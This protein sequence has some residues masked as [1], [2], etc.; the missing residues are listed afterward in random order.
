MTLLVLDLLSKA[1]DLQSVSLATFHDSVSELF[2]ESDD[3]HL[4][5]DKHLGGGHAEGHGILD[6]GLL[7][8][9]QASN[10]GVVQMGG[11]VSHLVRSSFV[12]FG[13]DAGNLGPVV[14]DSLLL[15]LV[16]ISK[17]G[18]DGL[19]RELRLVVPLELDV[20]PL[21]E[22]YAGKVLETVIPVVSTIILPMIQP[23]SEALVF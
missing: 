7:S 18:T 21:G 6:T 10:G 12:P 20:V 16:K 4:G 17:I 3:E 2:S 9:G 13:V 22:V 8:V 5:L 11:N 23:R 19:G 15:L 1:E 14:P